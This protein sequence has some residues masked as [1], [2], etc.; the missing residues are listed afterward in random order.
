M[1]KSKEKI[2]GIPLETFIDPVRTALRGYER[3]SEG[4]LKFDEDQAAQLVPTPDKPN[5]ARSATDFRYW[6]E[7]IGKLFVI[8]FKPDD[9]SGD[10][11]GYK[12]DDLVIDSAY[13][14]TTR[15]VPR[16]KTGTNSEGHLTIVRHKIEDPHA[17]PELFAGTFDLLGLDGRT[18]RKIGEL[19][20]LSTVS[21][22]GLK[23]LTTLTVGHRTGADGRPERFGDPHAV[24]S[25]A[26]DAVQV[27]AFM[28]I[29]E[30]MY[31]KYGD[32]LSLLHPQ[33]P[34]QP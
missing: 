14:R 22:A 24:Y 9:G 11:S 6:G 18:I 2:A 30:E 16:D 8:A 5:S 10:E 29:S 23:P 20:Q 4:L 34:R 3:E 7:T 26:P 33:E 31:Q 32:I 27:C 17:D 12:L 15:V 1:S 21:V 13:P 25:S 28:G 19:G